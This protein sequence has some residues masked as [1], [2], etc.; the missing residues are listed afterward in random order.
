MRKTL[1][2]LGLFLLTGTFSAVAKRKDAD[3]LNVD[4]LKYRIVY[5][6]KVVTDTTRT[7][8]VYKQ[9]QSYLD[10]GEKGVTRFYSHTYELRLTAICGEGR[11]DKLQRTG[12]TAASVHSP[13][14][15]SYGRES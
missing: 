10:I 2:L 14:A 1:F 8:Y 9:G 7:P 3:T 12:H 4:Q 5:N 11:K 13:T 6:T 15:M